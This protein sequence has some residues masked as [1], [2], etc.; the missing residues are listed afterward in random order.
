MWV[1]WEERDFPERVPVAGYERMK[2]LEDIVLNFKKENVKV[3]VVCCGVLYG[4]GETVF[5]EH[6]KSAWL[7]LPLS[8]PFIGFPPS[9]D[10][11][12]L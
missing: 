3:F 9:I 5:Y 7:Q 1:A 12:V 2:E 8:L 10:K 11:S 6:M 4:L